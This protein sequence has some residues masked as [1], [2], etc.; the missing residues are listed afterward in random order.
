MTHK[1][2]II[3]CSILLLLLRITN[4][5]TADDMCIITIDVPGKPWRIRMSIPRDY[6]L[7]D[8]NDLKSPVIKSMLMRAQWPTGD[9]LTLMCQ[10]SPRPETCELVAKRYLSEITKVKGLDPKTLKSSIQP[11]YVLYTYVGSYGLR[12]YW[13]AVFA[14]EDRC[15]H[16]MISKPQPR[17]DDNQEAAAIIDSL[18]FV[19]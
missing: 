18:N 5:V 8:L 16:L 1:C 13:Y 19:E 6:G 10:E 9:V 11:R 12:K 2:F 3:W 4:G 14:H 15:I 17:W 7:S